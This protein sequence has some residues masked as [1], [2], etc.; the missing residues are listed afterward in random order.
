MH[1]Y[2]YGNYNQKML[3]LLLFLDFSQYF[4]HFRE[5]I[6]EKEAVCKHY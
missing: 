1:L 2:Y 6:K 3:G 4:L 5:S